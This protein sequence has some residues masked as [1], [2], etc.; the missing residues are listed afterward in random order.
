MHKG[1]YLSNSRS[2]RHLTSTFYSGL[3]PILFAPADVFEV[4]KTRL[5]QFLGMPLFIKQFERCY[6]PFHLQL[7][8]VTPQ[9]LASTS[10]L[11]VLSALY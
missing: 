1:A 4:L 10:P 11:V 7:I 3:P 5:W 8:I 9:R 6:D 2:T